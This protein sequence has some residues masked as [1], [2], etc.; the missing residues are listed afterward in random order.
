MPTRINTQ[1][2]LGGWDGGGG[3]RGTPQAPPAAQIPL[4]GTVLASSQVS[5]T[6]RSCCLPSDPGAVLKLFSGC[7]LEGL[8]SSSSSAFLMARRTCELE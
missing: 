2:L 4:S 8:A 5:V 3:S 7:S 6:A 1:K